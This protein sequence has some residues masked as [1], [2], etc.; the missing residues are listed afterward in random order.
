MNYKKTEIYQISINVSMATIA[1][2]VLTELCNSTE[3]SGEGPGRPG[4]ITRSVT[5]TQESIR[6]SALGGK[7]VKR[8]LNVKNIDTKY[9]AVMAVERGEKSKS[10]IAKEFGVPANT[11]STWLKNK[12]SI[13]NAFT[14]FDPKRKN[15]RTGSFNNVETATLKWFKGARDQNIPISGPMLVTKAEEFAQKLDVTGFKASSGCS[16]MAPDDIQ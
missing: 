2:Q 14:Q 1:E 16:N 13:L 10:Q 9:E 7:G 8:K 4:G 12:E 15:T 5:A 11:L 6:K 3:Q